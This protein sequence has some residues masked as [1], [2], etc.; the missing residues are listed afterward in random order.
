[1]SVLAATSNSD[2]WDQQGRMAGT[3]PPKLPSGGLRVR[4][5]SL[6]ICGPGIEGGTSE[7]SRTTVPIAV[8]EPGP[9]SN[10]PG[11]PRGVC[12]TRSWDTC[13]AVFA[14]IG[15]H[16]SSCAP[17]SPLPIGA[18]DELP[19]EEDPHGD[20]FRS[21]A[22]CSGGREDPVLRVAQRVQAD[23]TCPVRLVRKA[24][25]QRLSPAAEAEIKADR[26]RE[27][28]SAKNGR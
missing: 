27:R 15:P 26:L 21:C 28:T 11:S 25:P 3:T 17:S 12:V 9:S 14:L 4:C 16:R 24:N 5:L 7:Y 8:W 1:M 22:R 13:V 10:L 6:A 19:P 18:K 2:D 23:S 20:Q